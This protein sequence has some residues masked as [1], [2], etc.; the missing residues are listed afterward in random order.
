MCD[1]IEQITAQSAIIYQQ[2]VVSKAMP[3]GNLTAMTDDERGKIEAWYL[4]Q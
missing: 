3:I 4:A 1:S 2:A